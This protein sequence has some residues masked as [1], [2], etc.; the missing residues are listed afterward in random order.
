M[1]CHGQK[2]QQNLNLKTTHEL[3]KHRVSILCCNWKHMTN[4]ELKF[5]EDIEKLKFTGR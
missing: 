2:I 5:K 4:L 1:K 3:K